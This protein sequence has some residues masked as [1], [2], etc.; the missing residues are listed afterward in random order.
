MELAS[1]NINGI[2]I[3]LVGVPHPCIPSPTPVKFM[4]AA[5]RMVV[6]HG[7]PTL[8]FL[9][10]GQENFRKSEVGRTVFDVL[11]TIVMTAQ[12]ACGN[13]KAYLCWVLQQSEED[14][15]QRPQDYTP[16]AFYQQQQ[17][18]HAAIDV[19]SMGT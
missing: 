7:S 13:P 16:L 10:D 19:Q 9:I 12:A 5:E 17:D 11:R 3:T 4:A 8:R 6:R 14:I 1:P 15:K 18:K 2:C